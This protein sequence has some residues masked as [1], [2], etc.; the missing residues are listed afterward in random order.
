M[1]E[2]PGANQSERTAGA[3]GSQENISPKKSFHRA[4]V[5]S[6]YPVFSKGYQPDQPIK[7]TD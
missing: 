1:V 4:F 2:S 6:H 5:L 3:K 7:P